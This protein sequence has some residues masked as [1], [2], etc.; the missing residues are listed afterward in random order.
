[1]KKD[2]FL[3]LK[4]WFEIAWFDPDFLH[5]PVTLPIV[6]I[7]G[8][9]G[10]VLLVEGLYM[11]WAS[12]VGKLR[13]RDALIGDLSLIGHERVLDVGCGRGLLMIGAAKRLLGGRAVGL[14]LWSQTDL[15]ENAREATLANARAEGVETQ[16]EVQDGDMRQ[17]PFENASFDVV[18]SSLAI[19]NISDPEGR[20]KALA[21]IVRVLKPGGKLALQDFRNVH[22]YALALTGLGCT[23][24]KE[25]SA[26]FWIFPPVTVVT[27]K[28]RV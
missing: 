18:I 16:V 24:V 10:I 12:R 7:A 13:A 3:A 14:D 25:S 2:D 28:K 26:S 8:I 17:M 20:R 9:T 21:E 5:G 1:M 23:E 19:H 27:A 22:D 4:I 15:S 11:Y 6:R